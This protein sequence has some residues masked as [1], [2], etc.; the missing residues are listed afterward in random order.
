MF[1]WDI[2]PFFPGPVL[3]LVGIL[4]F[5]GFAPVLA[6]LYADDEAVADQCVPVPEKAALISAGMNQ[7]KKLPDIPLPACADTALFIFRKA[8]GPMTAA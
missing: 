3:P 6:V 5:V 7:G 4:I 2:K 8:P 1:R